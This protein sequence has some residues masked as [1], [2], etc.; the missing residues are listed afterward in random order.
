MLGKFQTSQLRIEVEASSQLIR[1]YL[2]HPRKL[3]EWFW[4]GGFSSG[5]PEVFTPG[6]N[7]TTNLGLMK[8]GYQVEEVGDTCLRFLLYQGIDGYHEW[9]WGDG[10]VQSCLEG[11]SLLPLNL[12]QTTT[13]VGFKEFLKVKNHLNERSPV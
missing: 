9:L 8:I 10:W 7:F 11:V 4:L 2:I 1:D 13:L 3:R 12:A 6:L 5:L